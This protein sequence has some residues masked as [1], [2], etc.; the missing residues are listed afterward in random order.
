MN[1]VA[2]N[3]QLVR[4]FLSYLRVRVDNDP[5]DLNVLG[6]QGISLVAGTTV[7]TLQLNAR[8]AHHDQNDRRDG[9]SPRIDD[10]TRDDA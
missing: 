6:L 8:H 2:I 9:Q 4:E 7:P 5:G 1:P 3:P 10:F